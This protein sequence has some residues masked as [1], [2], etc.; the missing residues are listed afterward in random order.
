MVSSAALDPRTSGLLL[1]SQHPHLCLSPCSLTQRPADR[2]S[3]PQLCWETFVFCML[4]L[5][6]ALLTR[7]LAL[8]LSLYRC[9][10]SNT[11]SRK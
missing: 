4:F 7:R 10:G 6:W 1:P 3:P 11:S 5:P 8:P 2:H 9:F